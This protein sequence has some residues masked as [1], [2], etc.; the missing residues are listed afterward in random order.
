MAMVRKKQD[1]KYLEALRELITTGGGNRQCFDCGQK[2]PTY[3]NMTIGSFVCTRC[4]GV[5]RGITPPHRVKSISMA[6]FTQDEID[7]LKAHGNDVCAKTWLGL[8]DPK[9]AVHQDQREL[10][11]DKYERKRYY[12][13]PASP[14][15]SLT[16]ATN[17]KTTATTASTAAATS[18][19][20]TSSA[21]V[22]ASS[23]NSSQNNSNNKTQIQL[24]PPTSQRT[25]ANGLHKTSSTAISRP[26]HTTPQPQNGFS[27]S[28]SN[29]NTDAFGLHNGLNSSVGSMS[30]GALSDTSSCASANGFGAEAD[31]VADFGSADIFNATVASSPASS[32]GSSTT[33]NNGYAKI[34]PMKISA[35]AHQ[36]FMNGHGGGGGNNATTN[37]QNGNLSNGNTENF[38]DFD[39]A[40]IYNAAVEEPSNY[41]FVRK[42]AIRKKST[43]SISG[44]IIRRNERQLKDILE[45]D[46][47]ENAV[48]Y[49]NFNE[50]EVFGDTKTTANTN[51]SGGYSNLFDDFDV[52]L[53]LDDD[54]RQQT[55]FKEFE[56]D[57]ANV[58]VG[59]DHLANGSK[60][61]PLALAAHA[62]AMAVLGNQSHF[63]SQLQTANQWDVWPT[64]SMNVAAATLPT[65]SSTT[66][67]ATTPW[68]PSNNLIQ[69]HS[70]EVPPTQQQQHQ[71]H[72]YASIANF[73][74]GNLHTNQQQLQHSQSQY[75]PSS[76]FSTQSLTTFE[77]A[78]T[79]TMS[80]AVATSTTMPTSNMI[81]SSS[82]TTSLPIN[83]NNNKNSTT[84]GFNNNN[85]ISNHN[86]NNINN[87][88]NSSAPAEDRYA[89]LKDLDEQLR[90]SKAVAAQAASIVTANVV[91]SGFGNP[92]VNG[93]VNPFAAHHH[94]Q[95]QQQQQHQQQSAVV[96]PF[97]N[98][99]NNPTQNTT[100]QLFGQMTLIPNGIA[101]ANG[102]LNAQKTHTANT[103]FFNYTASGFTNAN[104][105]Q[106]QIQQQ[107]HQQ[108]HQQQQQQHQASL[109]Y[110]TSIQTGPNGCGFGFGTLQQQIASTGTGL[111]TNTF[112]NPFAAT[113]ALNSNNPFL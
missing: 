30:T 78:K 100:Q 1:D 57:Y 40:P 94:H 24:T 18:S 37:L 3:V 63:N 68:F 86:N 95:Q 65:K 31:F 21:S 36:Q 50:D 11:I 72:L 51:K 83:N 38:A 90:E 107:Q 6:T 9:R 87:N 10:M 102:F 12:L 43:S 7:F 32:V 73:N 111:T 28:L 81:T 61:T 108:Q 19:S 45:M 101:A 33:N 25:T 34:Q 56:S 41:Q 97:Q 54:N 14:L 58:A 92:N 89:A 93:T 98:A 105:P 13:E 75:F 47:N 69:Q 67:A 39:H 48:D 109:L 29:H 4:S 20:S 53:T 112:N 104:T 110:P 17:L 15:K 88:N 99:S 16:N 113:G 52:L 79:T 76:T 80:T 85:N 106:L 64:S 46:N 84:N 59:G 22:T 62:T 35:A 2:G 66:V 5:L 82:A 8:W 42:N 70:Y 23:A 91:D 26:Q 27:S 55:N 60:F 96:N 103:G 49:I 44:S 74:S 71:Q 77:T